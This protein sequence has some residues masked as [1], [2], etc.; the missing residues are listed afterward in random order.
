MIRQLAVIFAC[1][2]IGELIVFLTG[3][4]VPS[5]II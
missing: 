2:A 5:S 3:I 4:P 1:L